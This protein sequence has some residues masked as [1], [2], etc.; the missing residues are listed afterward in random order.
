MLQGQKIM[1]WNW[2]FDHTVWKI[3]Q[4]AENIQRNPL[5][6]L[7]EFKQISVNLNKNFKIKIG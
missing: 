5:T 4:K 1:N 6:L 3:M 7:G 2:V